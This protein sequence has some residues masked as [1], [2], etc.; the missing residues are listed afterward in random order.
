MNANI[1]LDSNTLKLIIKESVREA[2]RE[3][4]YKFFEMLLSFVD[5]EEQDEIESSFSP[6]NYS[7]E[8]FIDVTAWF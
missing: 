5:S 8:D 6:D 2:M 7:R 1:T 3:E 4:W